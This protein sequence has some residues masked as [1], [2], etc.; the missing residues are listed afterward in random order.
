MNYELNI[1]EEFLR[2]ICPVR[3]VPLPAVLLPPSLSVLWVILVTPA[4]TSGLSLVLASPELW[5]LTVL[6]APPL[7]LPADAARLGV[8]R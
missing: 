1:G 4:R 3:R 7:R 5:V 2:I 8:L 6:L